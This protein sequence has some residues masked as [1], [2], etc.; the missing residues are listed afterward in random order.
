MGKIVVVTAPSGCGKT[1]LI[2]RLLKD[3]PALQF[4]V[5][6]TTRAKRE[7]EIDGKDYYFVEE[8]VFLSM[9][10]QSQF[11]EWAQVHNAY[12]GT[13]MSEIDKAAKGDMLLDIDV[14]GAMTL[15]ERDVKALYMF[16]KPP[17]V[18]VLR[19]RLHARNTETPEAIELRLWN[20]KKELGYAGRFN[21]AIINDDLERAYAEFKETISRYLGTE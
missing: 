5:S 8:H 1:T 15:M 9:V 13:A 21:V 17:S 2:Q 3:M 18:D 19:E 7:H 4:S 14:Q 11:L 10:S 20:A 16:I 12:Y 6:Y